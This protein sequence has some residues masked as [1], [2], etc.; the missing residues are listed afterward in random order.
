[1]RTIR[2]LA[3]SVPLLLC[4]AAC[5]DDGGSGNADGGGEADVPAEGEWNGDLTV[6]VPAAAGGGF[7]IM[8][9]G[10]Q[11][12][13]AEAL[14]S[15]VVV[16]NVTGASGAIAAAEMLDQP[17]DGTSMMVVSRSI[18]SVPYSGSPEIDPVVD[19]A[20][21][22]VTVQDV[23]SLTVR[24]DAPYQSV[25]EFIDYAEQNP[26]EIQIGHS[27]VGSVWH[28]AGLLLEDAAGVE[29][30]FVPYDGGAASNAALLAGEIDAVLN[31]PSE[32]R[33]ITDGGDAVTLGV[34]GDERSATLP[35]VPTLQEEGIDVTYYVWRGYVVSAETPE[36]I[37]EELAARLEQAATSDE[38]VSAMEEVGFETTWIPAG[39][40]GDLIA[41]EDELVRELFEGEDF[42][43]TMPERL[44]E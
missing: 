44:S 40:F 21:L 39:E 37:Q 8:V 43:T 19:F 2:A 4:L 6:Y 30:S 1:M 15:S 41:E 7:D 11:D 29:F 36:A 33:P 38:Y 14:G 42:M 20:P 9:R 34:L 23:S 18:S 35:D 26:G 16:T 24:S 31:G 32:T 22:G 25:E 5:G 13:M 3:V 27:G 28:A 17:T 10:M 12:Q